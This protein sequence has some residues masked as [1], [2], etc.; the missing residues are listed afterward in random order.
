MST[1]FDIDNI[2]SIVIPIAKK[3]GVARVYLFGSV[4]RGEANENS[5]VDLR[6]DS[7]DIK[8]LFTLGGFYADIE[9]SLGKPIDVLTTKSLSNDFLNEI[10]NEEIILYEKE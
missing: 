10:K 3:Y 8:S 4:A 5:D 1:S 9:D 2:R 6:I 7:G